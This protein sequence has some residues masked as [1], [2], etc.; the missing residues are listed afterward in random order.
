MSAESLFKED[1]DLD[2]SRDKDKTLL[3]RFSVA[4]SSL[5]RLSLAGAE[6]ECLRKGDP[7][8]EEI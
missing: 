5:S 6:K 8:Q 7:R 3:P 1:E 4:L 2:T